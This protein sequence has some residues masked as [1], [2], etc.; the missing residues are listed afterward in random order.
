MEQAHRRRDSSRF[1][2]RLGQINSDGNGNDAYHDRVFN[3]EHPPSNCGH[4]C[5]PECNT[6]CLGEFHEWGDYNNGFTGIRY[7]QTNTLSLPNTFHAVIIDTPV[8]SGSI[9]SPF[10]P[11]VGRRL[12]RGGLAVAYG[13][14]EV[15]AVDPVVTGVTLGTDEVVVTLGGLGSAG[16]TA[17][18]GSQGFEVLGNCSGPTL[19]WKSSPIA[20]A[21]VS[22]VVLTELPVQP[23]AVRYLWYIAP[24]GTQPFRA[25]IYATADPIDAPPTSDKDLLPLAPFV[26]PLDSNETTV[27]AVQAAIYV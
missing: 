11:T 19:C 7:T 18:V 8:A 23:R 4:G 21:N 17:T 1:P 10:K 2:I 3:P 6:T 26:L 25:P 14:K 13:M 27:D 5:A 22:S 12:S 9:H 20:A 24:Y 16:L 15:H